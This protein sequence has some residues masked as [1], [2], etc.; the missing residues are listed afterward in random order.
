MVIAMVAHKQQIHSEDSNRGSSQ[1]QPS[2]VA[3]GCCK[4]L[5]HASRWNMWAHLHISKLG[6]W[7]CTVKDVP[8]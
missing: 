2:F 8:E 1:Q 4:M 7:Q 3:Q 5:K 6:Y